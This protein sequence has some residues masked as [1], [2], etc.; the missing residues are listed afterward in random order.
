MSNR[1]ESNAGWGGPSK[2]S[3]FRDRHAR[4]SCPTMFVRR[5]QAPIRRSSLPNPQARKG[6]HPKRPACSANKRVRFDPAAKPSCLATEVIWKLCYEDLTSTVK[7]CST[8]WPRSSTA[9]TVI[10]AVPA[11]CALPFRFPV[12]AGSV[13]EITVDLSDRREVFQASSG[14]E[15]LNTSHQQRGLRDYDTPRTVHRLL[16]CRCGYHGRRNGNCS[17][18]RKVVGV[19]CLHGDRWRRRCIRIRVDIGSSN[20]SDNDKPFHHRLL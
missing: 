11:F 18:R 7:L 14:K 16:D 3:P 1:K 8:Y 4:L 12:N 9:F 5:T 19:S 20:T 15:I 13:T 6:P 2:V 17:G 10:V